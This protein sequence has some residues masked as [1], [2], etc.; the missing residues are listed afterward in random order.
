V[1]WKEN[2]KKGRKKKG[3]EKGRQFGRG[4]ERRSTEDGDEEKKAT[5]TTT[6]TTFFLAVFRRQ[7]EKWTLGAPSCAQII[8]IPLARSTLH[9]KSLAK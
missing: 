4:T 3:R 1:S 2:K 9:I 5:T 7:I 8:T 6:T